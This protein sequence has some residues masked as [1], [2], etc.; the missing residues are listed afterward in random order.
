LKRVIPFSD[1][2]VR[3]AGRCGEP[4]DEFEFPDSWLTLE[5]MFGGVCTILPVMKA[6]TKRPTIA[7]VCRCVLKKT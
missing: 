4:E 1:D 5:E 7:A 3:L 2:E 6:R